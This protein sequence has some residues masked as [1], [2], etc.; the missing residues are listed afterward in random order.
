NRLGPELLPEGK[1]P[2]PTEFSASSVETWLHQP[3]HHAVDLRSDRSA[4]MAGHLKGAI[5]APLAGGKLPLSA[6]SYLTPEHHL[7]LVVE[8]ESQ[9]EPA[10]RQLIR[11]GLARIAGWV[12]AEKSHGNTTTTPSRTS[13]LGHLLELHPNAAVLDVRGSSE[14]ATSHVDG[15]KNIAYTRLAARLGELDRSK[16]QL[17]HCGSGLR[18]S[19]AVSF[20]ESQ[21]FDT[22]LVNGDFSAIPHELLAPRS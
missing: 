8:D 11:I 20:L 6:G 22:I 9:V 5:F 10:V 4:F 15:A 13:E 3:L 21:G 2:K 16:L 12:L 18:A 1:L 14:F 19:M 7:L 17:V